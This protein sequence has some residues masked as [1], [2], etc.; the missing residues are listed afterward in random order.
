MVE[1]ESDI[2]TSCV[3]NKKLYKAQRRIKTDI[4]SGH[5]GIGVGSGL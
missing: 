3:G 1:V 5:S 2:I 4:Q